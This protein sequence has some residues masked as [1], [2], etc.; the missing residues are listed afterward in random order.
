MLVCQLRHILAT[1][2]IYLTLKVQNL[3]V[4]F[5]LS[6]L[7]ITPGIDVGQGINVE[8]GKLD[9]NNKRRALNKRR[10]WKI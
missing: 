5:I 2:G 8:P 3:N 10:A 1:F 9:K 6:V 7:N 4:P